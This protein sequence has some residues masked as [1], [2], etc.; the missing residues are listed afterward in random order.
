MAGVTAK[1]EAAVQAAADNWG[2][3]SRKYA[4]EAI[5]QTELAAGTSRF[6]WAGGSAPTAIT[7][8]IWIFTNCLQRP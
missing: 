6:C 7:K 8:R 2:A 1:E 5:G 4:V 3:A